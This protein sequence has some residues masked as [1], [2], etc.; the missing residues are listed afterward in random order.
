M[1]ARINAKD[2]LLLGGT[3]LAILAGSYW[4]WHENV[5]QRVFLVNEL[6]VP[7]E[8]AVD[9]KVQKVP[10]RGL[11][12]VSL[13]QGVYPVRVT[14]GGEVIDE[15]PVEVPST[16]GVVAYN[17]LGASP[18]Y[19]T[20]V[21]Y[22]SETPSS[23]PSFEFHGGQRVVV[24]RKADY[25]FTTPPQS[26][27][28]KSSSTKSHTRWH[29]DRAQGGWETTVSILK[30]RS[31]RE[32]AL[33]VSLDVARH[34][35]KA[36]DAFATASNL[37]EELRGTELALAYL[38]SALEDHP[39]DYDL[40]RTFQHLL[41]RGDRFE[42]ARAYYRAFRQ[43]HPGG[44][45]VVLQARVEPPEAAVLLYKEVLAQEP[46][47]RMARR[48]LARV[49]LDL[50]RYGESA[51]L[52]EQVAADDPDYK[53]YVDDHVRSLLRQGSV[54]DALLAAT[55][56]V[57]KLPT[58]WRLAVLYADLAAM[59]EPLRLQPK[60]PAPAFI[61]KLAQKNRDPEVG[62]WMRSLAGLPVDEALIKKLRLQAE[63]M[64]HAARLQE[65]AAK[66]PGLAWVLCVKATPAALERVVSTV[67]LLLGAEFL[68]AGDAAAADLMLANVPDI[69]LPK[70]AFEAYVM[71]GLEHEEL[72]RL[73][74]DARAALD[75]VR[76]RKLQAEGASGESLY[77]A[78]RNREAWEGFVSRSMKSWPAPRPPKASSV[79]LKRRLAATSGDQGRPLL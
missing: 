40:H 48:G 10:P 12:E 73:D 3:L 56:A 33:R 46:E 78:A 52:F 51:A 47:N 35:P 64:I 16:S 38:Q 13:L 29:F 27:S 67:A 15:G 43:A 42:Q 8:I 75:F 49:L 22:G 70:A 63:P 39:D 61:D 58:E 76:G 34:D 17:V 32:V 1:K 23:S 66:D 54:A 71:E 31:L 59:A 50:G 30:E 11:V 20:A 62:I 37:L 14:A 41:R 28:V 6:S 44:L 55:K 53:Y 9:G 4:I 65:A 21:H 74:G 24:S 57:E 77:A 69:P 19:T 18:L 68:R 72:W 45:P 2:G 36:P 7:V 26:I 79:T 25:V 60:S 5:V